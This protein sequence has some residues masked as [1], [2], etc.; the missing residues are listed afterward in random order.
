MSRPVLI[1]AHRVNAISAIK[2]VVQDGANAIEADIHGSASRLVVDHDG[3]FAFSTELDPWL[4]ELQRVAAANARLTTVIFDLKYRQRDDVTRVLRS[5]V[6]QLV[7]TPLEIVFSVAN[8]GR[9]QELFTGDFLATLGERETVDISERTD[10]EQVSA[11][12]REHDVPRGYYAD[13]VF[14]FGTGQ[15]R[16][17]ANIAKARQ[18]RDAGKGIHRV[19]TWTYENSE[20]IEAK[21]RDGNDGIIVTGSRVNRAV[22]IVRSIDGIHLASR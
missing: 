16:I 21:L 10:P 2:S 1:I 22:G 15:A 17:D 3:A 19:Y 20:S 9:A 5:R 12:Y 6:R 4:R 13:G 7:T 14:R 8:L 11:Y 18:L